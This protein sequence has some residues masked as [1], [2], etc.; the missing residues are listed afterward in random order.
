MAKPLNY[1]Y[2]DGRPTE[3]GM[4]VLSL[5]MKQRV[6]NYT[7]VCTGPTRDDFKRNMEI[8]DGDELRARFNSR[9]LSGLVQTHSFQHAAD[10]L[11]QYV[12]SA[13]NAEDLRK[14]RE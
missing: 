10:A 5:V 2:A 3:F 6:G 7:L 14:Q 4:Q 1:L 11:W 12:N 9:W 8:R 13:D